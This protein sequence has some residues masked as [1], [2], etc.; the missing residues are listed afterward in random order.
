MTNPRTCPGPGDL[1]SP[2]EDDLDDEELELR[3]AARDR[4]DAD[5]IDRFERGEI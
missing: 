4:Y 5:L 3:Q 1:W 2:P